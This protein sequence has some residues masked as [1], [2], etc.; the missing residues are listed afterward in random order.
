LSRWRSARAAFS[1]ALLASRASRRNIEVVPVSPCGG[2]PRPSFRWQFW[3][4]R[5]LNSGPSPSDACVE[6]GD[7]T[8]FL[9]NKAL[10]S[11]KVPSSSKVMLAEGCEKESRLTSFCDVPAP[12][13]IRSNGSGFEKSVAGLVTAMTRA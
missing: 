6:D 3:Q 12:P 7:E 8:Q 1:S 9:R 13:C 4:A 10:P 5:S 11:L 2:R